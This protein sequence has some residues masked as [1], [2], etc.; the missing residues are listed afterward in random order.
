VLSICF[1]NLILAAMIEGNTKRY[2]MRM[3]CD[4]QFLETRRKVM[5]K[6]LF[7]KVVINMAKEVGQSQSELLTKTKMWMHLG[8]NPVLKKELAESM[9]FTTFQL[10][11]AIRVDSGLL[12]DSIYL[13]LID[14]FIFERSW[15]LKGKVE[16][17]ITEKQFVD[18]CLK[19]ASPVFATY[20]THSTSNQNMMA[21]LR[22]FMKLDLANLR[23]DWE[24]N[25][26][27][28]KLDMAENMSGLVGRSN[29]FS[30]QLAR[31]QAELRAEED[32][33]KILRNLQGR[34]DVI[35]A[36]YH[37]TED[38][39]ALRAR[40]FGNHD[41]PRDGYHRGSSSRGGDRN[42]S[43]LDRFA[44]DFGATRTSNWGQV[45]AGPMSNVL[46]PAMIANLENSIK[47]KV[48]HMLTGKIGALENLVQNVLQNNTQMM[49]GKVME[50]DTKL[51]HL[52]KRV[53]TGATQGGISG[54]EFHNLKKSVDN[55]MQMEMKRHIN[56]E[57]FMDKM[58][59]K[60]SGLETKLQLMFSRS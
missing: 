26:K 29:E 3:G 60:M 15:N 32:A 14:D 52:S 20:D 23:R 46:S 59:A 49:M 55:L 40:R 48:D 5:L 18:D 47:D 11:D 38:S 58:D 16:D 12:Q 31:D 1:V 50:N 21:K 34:L 19:I 37:E 30:K 51:N 53:D 36:E 54:P 10:E 56:L 7:R 13:D 44:G 4:K 9:F 8:M 28:L 25:R 45:G 33:N 41:D 57:A 35:D 27:Q 2:Q 42:L 24:S 22:F 39:R 6:K 17:K 43:D